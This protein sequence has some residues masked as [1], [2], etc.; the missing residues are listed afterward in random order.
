MKPVDSFR[1]A[2]R[3]ACLKWVRWKSYPVVLIRSAHFTTGYR[4][5][6]LR[7]ALRWTSSHDE[8]AAAAGLTYF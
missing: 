5:S 6:S 1:R 3:D 2:L 7:L 4:P 8:G